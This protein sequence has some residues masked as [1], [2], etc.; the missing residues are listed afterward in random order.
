MHASHAR[1]MHASHARSN[2]EADMRPIQSRRGPKGDSERRGRDGRAP[3][4]RRFLRFFWGAAGET[5]TVLMKLIM[6]KLRVTTQSGENGCFNNDTLGP[7][8]GVHSRTCASSKLPHDVPRSD[9]ASTRSQT[10]R[11]RKRG[12]VLRSPCY[13]QK[14]TRLST[15]AWGGASEDV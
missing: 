8:G 13:L 5:T 11:L 6:A 7:N 2:D 15:G 12:G 14:E 4:P 10:S 3:W 1:S 9:S